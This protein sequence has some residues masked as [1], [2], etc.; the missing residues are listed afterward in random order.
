MKLCLVSIATLLFV[1]CAT[2]SLPQ[3]PPLPPAAPE[4]ATQ[5][6]PHFFNALQESS[7]DDTLD[8]FLAQWESQ[9]SKP[10]NQI[11]LYEGLLLKAETLE[12][13]GQFS[14]AKDLLLDLRERSENRYPALYER[15]NLALVRAFEGLQSDDEAIA[16]LLQL[17]K[18]RPTANSLFY[19]VEAP[20]KLSMIYQKMGQTA[21]A[22]QYQTGATRKLTDLL[23]VGQIDKRVVL[24]R[25]YFQMGSVVLREIDSESFMANIRALENSQYFLLKSIE[26]E[27]PHWSERARQRLQD[28]YQAVVQFIK[29]ESLDLPDNFAREELIS[30]IKILLN[31]LAQTS[32]FV[33]LKSEQNLHQLQSFFSYKEDIERLLLLIFDQLLKLS[34]AQ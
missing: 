6:P 29:G 26:L 17:L 22:L 13:W 8:I 19:D 31:L 11:Y 14:E 21:L 16:L 27:D 30:K 2:S 24:P 4:Q 7:R 12:R 25:I 3:T 10:E 15:C 23:E 1:A 9:F 34:Q 33:Q 32:L 18:N 5:A 20:A 28:N